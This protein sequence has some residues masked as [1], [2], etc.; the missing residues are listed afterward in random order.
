VEDGSV[1]RPQVSRQPLDS[2][3]LDE[4]T[5]TQG[6][7]PKCNQLEP[8]FIVSGRASILFFLCLC[9]FTG[10]VS[11]YHVSEAD[12]RAPGW[13]SF[14]QFNRDVEN[15]DVSILLKNG[16]TRQATNVRVDHGRTLWQEATTGS[17]ISVSNDSIQTI[18][19]SGVVRGSFEGFFISL[20]S[21]V[22]VTG[23]FA[24][25][26]DAMFFALAAIPL[27]V[28]GSTVYGGVQGHTYRY[29]FSSTHQGLQ[30]D[31]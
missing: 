26:W 11:S 7:I 23:L 21:A 29:R 27:V 20:P 14:D 6:A 13:I 17:T 15:E 31:N 22:V 1:H 9:A 28:L 18:T 25:S 4:G 8:Q 5:V 12:D 16:T 30:A 3:A 2:L 10:C 24:R 19:Y